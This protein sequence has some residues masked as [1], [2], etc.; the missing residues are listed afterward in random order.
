[1][2]IRQFTNLP[3][4]KALNIVA[5]GTLAMGIAASI[6]ATPAQAVV[7]TTGQ[8][9]VLGRTADFFE[10]LNAG[11]GFS[12]N[13]NTNASVDTLGAPVGSDLAS[14]FNGNLGVAPTTGNF[15]YVSGSGDNLQYQLSNNLTFDFA[16][17]ISYT[18][19]SGST[20]QSLF[21]N[22]TQGVQFGI[23]NGTGFF[24]DRTNGDTTT[25][26]TNTFTVS[27]LPLVAGANGG[28]Y[29]ILASP[30]A[31]TPIPE[32]FTIIGTIIGGIAAFRMRKK[33]TGKN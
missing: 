24:T 3:N 8:L 12:I 2:K 27:D 25:A 33:L 30:V 32:P 16:N 5:V 15:E 10:N 4:I 17:N 7:F 22:T 18:I 29:S 1:M 20:F 14:L 13:F 26:L 28:N 23:T 21:N 31:A 11:S 9:S 6:S 19:N